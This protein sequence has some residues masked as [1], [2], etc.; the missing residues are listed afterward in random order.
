MPAGRIHAQ[1]AESRQALGEG[2]LGLDTLRLAHAPDAVI[3]AAGMTRISDQ[4]E[5]ELIYALLPM[6]W[7]R[8]LPTEAAG[9]ILRLAFEVAGF[10]LVRAGADPPTSPRS[11]SWNG[12]G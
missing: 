10:E 6:Y 4:P 5:P 2:G 11:G 9:E 12:S 8:G 7:G 1:V 3:G